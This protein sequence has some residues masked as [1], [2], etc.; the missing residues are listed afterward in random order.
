MKKNK[1]KGSITIKMEKL[2]WDESK[3]QVKGDEVDGRQ[4]ARKIQPYAL[5]EY[6][7]ESTEMTRSQGKTRKCCMNKIQNCLKN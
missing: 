3:I 6:I 5:G 2:G 4:R 7:R 1:K